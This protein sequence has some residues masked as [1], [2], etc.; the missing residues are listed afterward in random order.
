MLTSRGWWF[1][2][3]VLLTCGIGAAFSPRCGHGI[4]IVGFTLLAW[5]LWEWA[6][7][8]Y[9]YYFVLPRVI[10]RREVSDERKA[11]PILWAAGEFDV[12]VQIAIAGPGSLPYVVLA[13]W[14]PTD[15]H[16]VDG[17][18]EVAAVIRSGQPATISYRL[19]VPF[20]A[21]SALKASAFASPTAKGSSIT[22]QSLPTAPRTS[23]CRG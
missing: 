12:R 18:D 23:C 21:R 3:V 6:Q 19:N 9:R 2:L 7:F 5:F 1:F 4:A 22:A 16:F 10:L 15:A 14:V 17:S 13:D 20:P 11:V 8:A